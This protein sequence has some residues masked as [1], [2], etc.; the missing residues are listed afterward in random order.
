MRFIA[1]INGGGVTLKIK[2]SQTINHSQGQQTDEG[3]RRQSTTYEGVDDGV[4]RTI[5]VN[6]RDCDGQHR[7]ITESFCSWGRL[8][9]LD[10][11]PDWQCTSSGR[12]H[13]DAHAQ[14]MGY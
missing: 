11:Y 13:Y 12:T 3:Y 14:A 7:T 2:P 9:E 8:K 4:C 10:G 1:W 5:C 6:E